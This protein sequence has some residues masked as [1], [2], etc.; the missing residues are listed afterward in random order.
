MYLEFRKVV[1]KKIKMRGKHSCQMFYIHVHITLANQNPHLNSRLLEPKSAEDFII[2][3]FIIII[4]IIFFL[5]GG[6]LL[7]CYIHA[8]F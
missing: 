8:Q 5:E 1:A 7:C 2:I 3:I 4:I 6:V